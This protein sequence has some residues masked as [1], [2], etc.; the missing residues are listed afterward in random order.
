MVSIELSELE[1]KI[2]IPEDNMG[3]FDCEDE[4]LN[5]FIR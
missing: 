2:L 3:T 1:I 4:E 5:G